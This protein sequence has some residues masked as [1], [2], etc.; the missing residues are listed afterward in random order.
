MGQAEAVRTA[1]AKAIVGWTKNPSVK[2]KILR[3]RS[4]SPR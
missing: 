4:K 1:I 2:K 3:T